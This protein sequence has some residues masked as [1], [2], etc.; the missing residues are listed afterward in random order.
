MLV[1]VALARFGTFRSSIF[2]YCEP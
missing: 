1:H 2:K